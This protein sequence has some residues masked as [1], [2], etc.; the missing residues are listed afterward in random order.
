MLKAV[1]ACLLF[2]S[3]IANT[4]ADDELYFASLAIFSVGA[5]NGCA[6]MQTFEPASRRTIEGFQPSPAFMK[7]ACSHFHAAWQ[8]A[9]PADASNV[10][11][12]I[13]VW[14]KDSPDG[15]TFLQQVQM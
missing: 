1:V 13:A 11:Y 9:I 10:S 5:S 6:L 3:A 4:F 12:E 8:T 2:T 15:P 7:A 14:H